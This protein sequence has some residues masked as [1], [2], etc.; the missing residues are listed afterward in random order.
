MKKNNYCP[1]NMVKL[2]LFGK[3]GQEFA[4]VRGSSVV[5]INRFTHRK[6]KPFLCI[7]RYSEESLAFLFTKIRYLRFIKREK[8]RRYENL[9]GKRL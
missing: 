8:I 5:F 2:A 3:Y 7:I 4:R 6:Q 9:Q 1:L